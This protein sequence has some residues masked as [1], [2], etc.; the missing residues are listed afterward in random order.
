MNLKISANKIS[1]M[2]QRDKKEKDRREESA[3]AFIIKGEGL[4]CT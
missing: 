2:K 4:M 1:R 3:K